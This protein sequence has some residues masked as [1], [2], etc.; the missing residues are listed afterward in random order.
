MTKVTA[1]CQRVGGYLLEND[2]KTALVLENLRPAKDATDVLFLRYGLV[3]K[4]P[5]EHIFP[6]FLLDDWGREV[7]GLK[8]YAWLSENGER[9]PRGEIFGFEQDGRETQCFLRELELYARV[10]CYAYTAVDSAVETGRLLDAILLPDVAVDK[11]ERIKRPSDLKRPLRTARVS[12]WQIPANRDGFDFSL[13]D[14]PVNPG[15]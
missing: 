10:P 1:I 11:V 8:L 15:Y 6:A 4:G 12:W 9:F 2:G 3:T 14:E 5:E 7:R 13:L